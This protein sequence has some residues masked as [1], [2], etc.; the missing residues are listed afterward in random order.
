MNIKQIATIAIAFACI[1]NGISAAITQINEEQLAQA[2]IQEELTVGDIVLYDKHVYTVDQF[3]ISENDNF[4]DVIFT[5]K[6]PVEFLSTTW[7]NEF[8][9]ISVTK[10]TEPLHPTWKI[11]NEAARTNTVHDVSIYRYK[12]LNDG[13]IGVATIGSFLGYVLVASMLR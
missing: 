13:K 1:T 4:Y 11:E 2:F 8:V 5:L 10:G 12:R 3:Q 6:K 7:G 9:E